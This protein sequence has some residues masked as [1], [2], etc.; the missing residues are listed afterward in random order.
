MDL[1]GN[2]NDTDTLDVQYSAAV[3]GFAECGISNWQKLQYV[4]LAWPSSK[5]YSVDA[6]IG[7][8]ASY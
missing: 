1:I 8:L 2:L 4:L 5:L 3:K 6:F 7:Y